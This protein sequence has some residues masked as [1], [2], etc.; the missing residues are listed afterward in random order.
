MV[1]KPRAAAT[2]RAIRAPVAVASC[3]A[4]KLAKPKVFTVYAGSLDDPSLFH[5][6]VAIFTRD[7]PN[8]GCVTARAH[9]LRKG[10]LCPSSEILR[11]EA[12]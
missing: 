11:Q 9:H 1:P 2:P 12:A 10:R 3:L 5:P 7:R 4:V 8:L 6:T